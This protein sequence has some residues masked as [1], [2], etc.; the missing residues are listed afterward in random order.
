MLAQALVEY[1]MLS[2]LVESIQR[3]A[4]TIEDFVRRK[5]PTVVMGVL[6]VAML[7]MLLRH[8]R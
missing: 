6:V 1:G 8:R 4:V 7:G 2:A 5:D 3:T